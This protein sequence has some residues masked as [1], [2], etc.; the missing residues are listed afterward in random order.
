MTHRIEESSST[1]SQRGLRLP[2][3][4]T[5]ARQGLLSLS[6]DTR[7]AASLFTLSLL[8]SVI[9]MVRTAC[10]PE[11]D[12]LAGVIID[13]AT[14]NIAPAKNLLAGYG[15]SFDRLHRTNGVQ[16]LWALLAIPIA[17]LSPDAFTTL[18]LLVL[19]GGLCWA[20]ASCILYVALQRVAAYTA[21][22]AST[23]FLFAGFTQRNAMQ[24][25]ENGISAVCLAALVYLCLKQPVNPDTRLG[26]VLAL[27]ALARVEAVILP[28]SFGL[29]ALSGAF[30]KQNTWRARWR[31]A[32][33][34]MTPTAVCFGTYV[35]LNLTYFGG[36]LPVSG[37]AKHFYNR[38]FFAQ[39]GWPFGGFVGTLKFHLQYPWELG[40]HSLS[41]SSARLVHWMSGV[42]IGWQ[43]IQV[44]Y[45]CLIVGALLFGLWVY[46]AKVF[47]IIRADR[48]R[49]CM[50]GLFLFYVVIHLA[51]LLFANPYFTLYGI[52]YFT[53]QLLLVSVAVAIAFGL[54]ASAAE[55]AIG[56]VRPGRT[57]TRVLL[58]RC[59][60]IGIVLL[61]VPVVFGVERVD[62]DA[63]MMLV[64]RRAGEWLNSRLPAGQR[65]GTVSSGVV[66][67]YA[68]NHHVINLDGLINDFE[69]FQYL[70]TARVPQYID[71]EGIS[72]FAD[73]SA[74]ER[75]KDGIA[76][77]G[78]IPLERLELV[79]W[80]PVPDGVNAYCIWRILPGESRR[81]FMDPCQ[82]PADQRSQLEFAALV[83][84]QFPVVEETELAE[85]L[86]RHPGSLVATSVRR[87]ANAALQHIVL[88]EEQFRRL[89]WTRAGLDI[90]GNRGGVFA[91]RVQLLSVESPSWTVRRGGE[92]VY[93][94]YWQAV[95]EPLEKDASIDVYIHPKQPGW[96]WHRGTPSHGTFPF[97]RW[98]K[99]DVVADT[100]VI[101]IPGDISP[102]VYP[103]HVGLWDDAVGWL[104]VDGPS[105]IAKAGM[106]FVGN[107]TI[108]R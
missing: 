34:L 70:T 105:D 78:V 101:P 14:Y 60:A 65:I 55:A 10:L 89:R 108:E 67:H 41:L 28:V 40:T 81:R 96:V 92:W 52:W 42:R 68:S 69:Y 16:P 64:F 3:L 84:K 87:K 13:D 7:I 23:V 8:L 95:G 20:A 93:T 9:G 85:Y 48:A 102:G 11:R 36:L 58:L 4:P 50:V 59:F 26:L 107:L 66:N 56:R 39:S 53:P 21:C 27:I 91:G 57:N 43:H 44:L 74:V 32:L 31:V 94:R 30:T 54:F 71:Y 88:S 22:L 103:V 61:N 104:A 99:G 83:L 5:S 47:P 62:G 25:M 6:R 97:S 33:T 98:R 24:G 100:Y 73:Y 79:R 90:N 38:Q 75:W 106:V 51:L 72:Y 15:Y 29:A 18:R 35:L 77:Q 49:A 1:L 2:L 17:A 45:T 37:A 76:W 46:R 12:F 19:L 82:S 86:S 63:N 80:W